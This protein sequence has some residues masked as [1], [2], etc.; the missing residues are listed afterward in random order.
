[1]PQDVAI[2]NWVINTWNELEREGYIETTITHPRSS[3]DTRWLL[4]NN[5][6]RYDESERRLVPV[7]TTT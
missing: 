2:P 4:D 5:F 7:S 6:A 1:M 3:P